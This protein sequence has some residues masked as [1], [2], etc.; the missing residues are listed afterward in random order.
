MVKTARP[1][2]DKK[3]QIVDK[4][5]QIVHKN[6]KLL[7]TFSETLLLPEPAYA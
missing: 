1:I 5:T 4:K 7:I 6:Q 2:V 3:S